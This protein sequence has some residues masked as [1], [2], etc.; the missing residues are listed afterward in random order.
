M[1]RHTTQPVVVLHESRAAGYISVRQQG[2]NMP[3]YGAA[4]IRSARNLQI[5][6]R[7]Y[8]TPDGHEVTGGHFPDHGAELAQL[9]R[10]C[11]DH[12]RERVP[13]H[14]AADPGR[15][16]T[17][18]EGEGRFRLRDVCRIKGYG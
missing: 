14:L 11:H 17:D 7:M 9:R 16:L 5:L 2:Q 6:G 8:V 10:R 13:Q 12:A 15:T 4:L 18:H 3:A 1:S